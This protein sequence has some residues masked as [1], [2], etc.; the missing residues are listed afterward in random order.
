MNYAE[1]K[2]QVLGEYGAEARQ[3]KHLEDDLQE[4]VCTFLKWALPEDATYWAVPNGGLRHT[5]EAQRMT[6]LG[7]RAGIPDLHI[8]FR[9]KLHCIELKAPRG[10]LS[11]VQVQTVEKLLKCGVPTIVCRSVEAVE[12]ALRTWWIPLQAKLA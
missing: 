3:R 11:E 4:A 1:Y 9:G 5:R 8:A 6:R 10:T 12:Q 2:E 7:V